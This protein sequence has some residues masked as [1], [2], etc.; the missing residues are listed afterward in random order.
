MKQS[1]WLKV[2]S[3]VWLGGAAWAHLTTRGD[4]S[5]FVGVAMAFMLTSEIVRA[6]GK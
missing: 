3:L 1:A 6:L 4:V 5:F 2:W